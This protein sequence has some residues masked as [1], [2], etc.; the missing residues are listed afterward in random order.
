MNK[1]ITA[2]ALIK[3]IAEAKPMAKVEGDEDLYARPKGEIDV[4]DD[5]LCSLVVH[6]DLGSSLDMGFFQIDVG[7][8]CITVSRNVDGPGDDYEFEGT[9]IKYE[10]GVGK[11][12]VV[13]AIKENVKFPKYDAMQYSDTDFDP[14]DVE[15]SIEV[16]DGDV[17]AEDDEGNIY[18]Y[19]DESEVPEDQTVIE[20]G[21]AIHRLVEEWAENDGEADGELVESFGPWS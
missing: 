6:Q 9:E 17:F 10:R 4:G 8:V 11:E 21:D 18:C 5:G 7:G 15:D 2:K 19:T 1:T 13:R 12:D 3:E 20:S 16:E 14:D